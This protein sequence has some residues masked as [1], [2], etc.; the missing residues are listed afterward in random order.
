[1]DYE[2]VTGSMTREIN[3]AILE[4]ALNVA[5]RNKSKAAKLLNISRYKFIRELNKVNGPVG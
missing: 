1:M 3:K 4:N 5:G 2:G